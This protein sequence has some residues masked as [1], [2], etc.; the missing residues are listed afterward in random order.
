V[1]HF[2]SIKE[3]STGLFADRGSKFYAFAYPVQT[4]EEIKIWLEHLRKEHFKA[5]HHCFAW[6]LG[7]DGQRFR[8]TDDG[9]PGGTAGRPILAQIDK[10]NLT[11]VLVVVVRYFGGT[12]LGTSGLIN[13]YREGAHEALQASI[14][15]T[16]YLQDTIDIQLTY[17]RLAT[18]TQILH[19]TEAQITDQQWT[20]RDCTV[21]IQIR[22][23]LT[24]T[25]LDQLK[26]G[27]HDLPISEA[28]G[29]DWPIDVTVKVR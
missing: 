1:D 11:D 5:R 23:S 17:E 3:P 9:E 27:L 13:A 20:D 29:L 8:S 22:K 28:N 15:I 4:E 19:S 14:R 18:C 10:H 7:M 24:Q 21:T 6:R 26:S 25:I 16:H 12:L 2:D